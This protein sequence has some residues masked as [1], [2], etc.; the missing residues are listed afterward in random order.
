MMHDLKRSC[1]GLAVAGLAILT[2]CES[3]SRPWLSQ[4][5]S[6]PS[7]LQEVRIMAK[8]ME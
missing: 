5:L 3:A 7:G 8:G 2:G 4:R 1:C 6:A